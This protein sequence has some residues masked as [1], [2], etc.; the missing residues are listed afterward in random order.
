MDYLFLGAGLTD[1][2]QERQSPPK[3][4]GELDPS[5]LSSLLSDLSTQ[6]ASLYDS[7][8]PRTAFM[9]FTGHSDPR[10]MVALNTRKSTFEIAVRG[11]RAV[12]E[13]QKDVRWTTS[14]ARE[15]EEEVE[16]AKRG[17]LFLAIK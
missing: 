12:D 1:K 10:N 14:D 5:L 17:L 13:L 11:G 7:V 16:K 8:P 2:E 3:A 9:I 4:K 6:L 15:L